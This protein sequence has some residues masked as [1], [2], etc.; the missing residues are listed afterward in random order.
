M[1][2]MDPDTEF[3]ALATLYQS[4]VADMKS[5]YPAW[6]VVGQRAVKLSAALKT[7]V[8]ALTAFNDSVQHVSDLASNLKGA[9]RDV[10][11][12]VTRVCMRQRA[13]EGR[14]KSLSDALGD[15]LAVGVHAR[16]AFWKGRT[17]EMDKNAAKHLKKTRSR[18][19]RP[20]ET[21]MATQRGLCKQLLAEQRAQF[22]F[23]L[24]QM[25]PVLTAEVALLDEASHI[26]PSVESL[27]S[28]MKHVDGEQ[29]VETI[30]ADLTQGAESAWKTCLGTAGVSFSISSSTTTTSSEG[31]GGSSRMT[32]PSVMMGYDDTSSNANADIDLTP[33]QH[34]HPS[35][36]QPIQHIYASTLP[37]QPPSS[38]SS[39]SHPHHRLGGGSISSTPSIPRPVLPPSMPTNGINN[40]HTLGRRLSST[41]VPVPPTP[42]SLTSSGASPTEISAAVSSFRGSSS[43]LRRPQSFAGGGLGGSV[44]MTGNGYAATPLLTPATTIGGGAYGASSSFSYGGSSSSSS[45][46][47]AH[48]A[49]SSMIAETVQ[50]IEGLG[51]DLDHFCTPRADGIS[52]TLRRGEYADVYMRN[53][54]GGAVRVR[55]DSQCR[56]LP[57]SRRSS[58]ITSA[59]PNAPSVADARLSIVSGQSGAS[60]LRASRQSL[61]S[62]GGSGCEA[63]PT[64]PAPYNLI[65]TTPVSFRPQSQYATAGYGRQF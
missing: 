46:A 34:H 40:R 31:D 57:P 4:V 7:T 38:N 63:P 33:Q 19:T 29:L 24:S 16:T 49:T 18:K 27:E 15:E 37:N 28:T 35:H 14:L 64:G 41:S 3:N 58:A 26:R 36:G 65:D 45:S 59:T 9:S 32:S 39:F 44:V 43:E 12:C 53:N 6:E 20:D 8:T 52:T 54:G 30:L 2:A 55:P 60:S 23:F 11:A 5:S 42:T 1:V 25:Q 51:N 62:D 50:A 22:A 56:P 10:G 13:L 21:S 47:S 61:A 17:T 48:Q